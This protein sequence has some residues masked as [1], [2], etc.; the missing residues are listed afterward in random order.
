MESDDVRVRVYGDS[1][2]D[3]YERE[4]HGP[5]LQHARAGDR[6]F[7]ETKLPMAVRVFAAYSICKEVKLRLAKRQRACVLV[8]IPTDALHLREWPAR[9]VILTAREFTRMDATKLESTPIRVI[10]AI[11]R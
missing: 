10:R 6:R 8:P 11:H 7:R 9:C 2:T 1:G 3:P 4:I 5:R